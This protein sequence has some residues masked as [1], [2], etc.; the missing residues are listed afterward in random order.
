MRIASRMSGRVQRW[1]RTG[2]VVIV[3]VAASVSLFVSPV[4]AEPAPCPDSLAP[5]PASLVTEGDKKDKNNNGLVC[6]KL[7]DDGKFHGGPDDVTDDI[8]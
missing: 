5:L 8:I 6:A 4:T 1:A 7:G 2:V 3:T